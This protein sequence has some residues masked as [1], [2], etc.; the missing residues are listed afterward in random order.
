MS[1]PTPP[2]HISCQSRVLAAFHY[3]SLTHPSLNPPRVGLLSTV[4]FNAGNE[5][6][7]DKRYADQEHVGYPGMSRIPIALLLSFTSFPLGLPVIAEPAPASL[8]PSRGTGFEGVPLAPRPTATL[9]GFPG[10]FTNGVSE[11]AQIGVGI[12]IVVLTGFVT[13]LTWRIAG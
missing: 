5:L 4:D 12:W 10:L 6:C 3:G 9:S 13:W 2:I 11:G 1:N 8:P 7:D